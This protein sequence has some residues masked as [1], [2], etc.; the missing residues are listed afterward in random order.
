MIHELYSERIKWFEEMGSNNLHSTTDKTWKKNEGK[1]KALL[2][3]HFSFLEGAH[4]CTQTYLCIQA[5]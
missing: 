3:F 4:M 1:K 2:K 5:S